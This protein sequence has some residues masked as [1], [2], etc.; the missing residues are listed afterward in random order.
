MANCV[1]TLDE[2]FPPARLVFL[3]IGGHGSR[4]NAG[5]AGLRRLPFSKGSEKAS[6]GARWLGTRWACSVASSLPLAF[7]PLPGERAARTRPEGAAAEGEPRLPLVLP[8]PP[9]P[10]PNL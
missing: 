4:W 8:F 10:S 7:S 3:R 2:P 6:Q 1:M 5:S 9:R